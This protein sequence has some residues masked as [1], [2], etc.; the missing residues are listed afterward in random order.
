MYYKENLE[1][2]IVS[3]T[4]LTVVLERMNVVAPDMMVED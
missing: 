2:T 4:I 1:K 3:S